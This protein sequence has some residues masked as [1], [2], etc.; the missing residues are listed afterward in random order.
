MRMCACVY[1]CVV[2]VCVCG[3]CVCVCGGCVGVVCGGVC[4]WVGGINTYINRDLCVCIQLSKFV[5]VI[6]CII[7]I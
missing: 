6:A 4:G 2:G 1:V 3:V 5:L 7:I